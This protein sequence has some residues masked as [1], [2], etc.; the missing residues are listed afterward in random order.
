MDINLVDTN[1]DKESVTMPI[2]QG[3]LYA[4]GKKRNLPNNVIFCEGL[5]SMLSNI[6]KSYKIKYLVTYLFLGLRDKEVKI[7]FDDESNFYDYNNVE[8]ATWIVK[9]FLDQKIRSI[10]KSNADKAAVDE[11]AAVDSYAIQI[12]PPF[13]QQPWLPV[14]VDYMQANAGMYA[15][16]STPTIT[17]MDMEMEILAIGYLKTQLQVSNGIVDTAITAIEAVISQ[18]QLGDTPVLGDTYVRLAIEYLKTQLPQNN[19]HVDT[20][21]GVIEARLSQ[22]MLRNA[23][24]DTVGDTVVCLE[25]IPFAPTVVGDTPTAGDDV[26]DDATKRMSFTSDST[27]TV[28]DMS[29]SSTDTFQ[30]FMD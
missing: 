21:F 25:P 22:S 15:S 20:A 5:K 4:G 13:P 8:H 19:S 10:L 12:L 26:C 1:C 30:G 14:E 7:W 28:D 9:S 16:T 29:L 6:N 27:F 24:G 2:F 17:S 11:K 18:S 23:P 3:N